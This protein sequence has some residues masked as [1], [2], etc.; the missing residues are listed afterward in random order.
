MSTICVGD[1]HG[2]I[3]VAEEMLQEKNKNII[4]MGDFLDSF[5]RNRHDQLDLLIMVLDAVKSRPEV[6]SLMGNHELSYL[7]MQYRCSGHSWQLDGNLTEEIKQDMRDNLSLWVE[8]EGFFLSH[9]GMSRKW[10][11]E[12]W[13]DDIFGYLEEVSLPTIYQI[14][15]SR[16][17]YHNVGGLLWC[18]Y[19]ADFQPLHELKQVFG[20]TATNL[21]G[22]GNGI[23]TKDERNYCIDCLDRVN[24]VL[25]ISDGKAEILTF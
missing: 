22:E 3:E 9:A 13:R 24:E 2:K 14:G 16:G 19:H 17:G 10:I 4:F 23:R 7:E 5:D 11:P 20:H 1:L 21:P 8:D 18:D 6:S 12:K 15:Q 25:E